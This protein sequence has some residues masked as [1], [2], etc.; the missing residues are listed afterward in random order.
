[1]DI[2]LIW[3]KVNVLLLGPGLLIMLYADFIVLMLS[4]IWP[5]GLRSSI[6]K[7]LSIEIRTENY[8][9]SYYSYLLKRYV[10]KRTIKQVIRYINSSAPWGLRL[11]VL[12]SYCLYIYYALCA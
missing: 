10:A 1:M 6:F 8:G 9:D 7:G 12:V 4:R 3:S 2:E 11:L 5:G